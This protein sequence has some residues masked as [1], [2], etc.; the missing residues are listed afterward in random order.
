[1]PML[2]RGCKAKVRSM[3]WPKELWQQEKGA[4]AIEYGLIAAL[5]VIASIATIGQVADTTITMWNDVN[6]RSTAAMK[7]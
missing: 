2:R 4:T 7:K 6:S 3:C 5:I 1:M